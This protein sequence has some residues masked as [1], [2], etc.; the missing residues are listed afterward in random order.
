M[1]DILTSKRPVCNKPL[2]ILKKLKPIFFLSKFLKKK[3]IKKN[4][5]FNLK[6]TEEQRIL[7]N[8]KLYKSYKVRHKNV[9][10]ESGRFRSIINEVNLKRHFF[11][12]YLTKNE[13]PSFKKRAN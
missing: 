12:K 10:L 8:I 11:K 13:L 3:K 6:L 9:C 7:P 1:R 2:K 4:F 5:F